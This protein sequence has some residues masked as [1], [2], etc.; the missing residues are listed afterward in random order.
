VLH[1]VV[2]SVSPGEANVTR[3]G[4]DLGPAPV[5]LHLAADETATLV[6]TRKGYKAKTVKIDASTP[7]QAVTLDSASVPRPIAAPAAP[8]GGI[9]D[10]G[11]PFAKK[12]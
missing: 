10:V 12:R 9:D 5:V 11:D 3:D 7:R 2:V 4:A 1:E 8:A 6:I